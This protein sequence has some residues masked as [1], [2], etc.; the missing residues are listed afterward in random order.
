MKQTNRLAVLTFKKFE[1]EGE[2]QYTEESVNIDLDALCV[3]L[4]ND[5][6]CNAEMECCGCFQIQ[7]AWCKI[8]KLSSPECA[9]LLK[10]ACAFI[11]RDH[12]YRFFVMLSDTLRKKNIYTCARPVVIIKVFLPAFLASNNFVTLYFSR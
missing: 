3:L 6:S 1:V 11:V 2:Y 10:H 9:P 4:Q 8:M 7:N 12:L 5:Q